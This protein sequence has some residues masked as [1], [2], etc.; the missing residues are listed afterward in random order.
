MPIT[1]RSTSSILFILIFGVMLAGC[2]DAD[3]N[4]NAEKSQIIRPVKTYTVKPTASVFQ[5]KYSAVVLPS[6]EASLSFRVSGRVV[7]LDRKSVV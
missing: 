4:S 2:S 3:K 6:Q 1:F 7:L 5:R